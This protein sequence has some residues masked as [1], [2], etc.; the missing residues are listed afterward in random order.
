LTKLLFQD[1]ERL[2]SHTNEVVIIL[3]W[4]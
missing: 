4:Y 2:R 1:E 3:S